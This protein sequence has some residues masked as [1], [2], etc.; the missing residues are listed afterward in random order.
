M[1]AFFAPASPRLEVF[2][3]EQRLDEAGFEGRLLSSSYAPPAGHPLTR[4]SSPAR[5]RSFA[6]TPGRGFVTIAYD[7]LVWHGRLA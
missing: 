6:R 5:P 4:R 7:T 1:R 2:E 3:N